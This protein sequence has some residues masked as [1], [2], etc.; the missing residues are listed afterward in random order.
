MALFRAMGSSAF[1]IIEAIHGVAEGKLKWTSKWEER[2]RGSVI[3][4]SS[5]SKVGGWFS[6]A[7]SGVSSGGSW[8]GS[9]ISSGTRSVADSLSR[10]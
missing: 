2:S 1:L 9:K 8:M 5:G 6:K 7:V 10:R 3:S 4:S